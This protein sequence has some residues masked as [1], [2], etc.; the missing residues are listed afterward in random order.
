[1]E[2][3][4]NLGA[5]VHSISANGHEEAVELPISMAAMSALGYFCGVAAIVALCVKPYQQDRSVRFNAFQSLLF[6]AAWIVGYL[7]I[8]MVTGI[9]GAIFQ[10]IFGAL[11]LY[12]LASLF[13][14]ISP[15]L[16]GLFTLAMFVAWVVL[17]V[18]A[19]NGK[20]LRLPVLGKIA[21]RLAQ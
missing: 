21:Q 3:T 6:S 10:L 14:V 9:L 4:T 2:N 11:K 16:T 13:I 15:V 5:Q 20:T 19:A 1:M 8:L 18:Q 12:V 17:M 7:G